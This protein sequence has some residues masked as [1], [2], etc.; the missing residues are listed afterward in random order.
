MN[1]RF[2]QTNEENIRKNIFQTRF[3]KDFLNFNE[4][5]KFDFYEKKRDK[6]KKNSKFS[7]QSFLFSYFIYS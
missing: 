6:T 4:C 2:K 7:T 3:Q 1:L 5:L